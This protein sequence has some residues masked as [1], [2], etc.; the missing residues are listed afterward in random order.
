M[1][2]TSAGSHPH[3]ADGAHDHAHHPPHDHHHDHSPHPS[4]VIEDEAGN[5]EGQQ[6]VD[7]LQ[8]L[9]ARKG[10][11]SN[12]EVTLEI[13]NIEAPGTHLGAQLVAR[14]WVDPAFKARLL[15]NG[16]DGAA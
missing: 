16:K 15:A 10:I 4:L 7:A 14:A 8:A 9:L 11:L 6:L 2:T 13:Q 3:A 1:S 5:L 12:G